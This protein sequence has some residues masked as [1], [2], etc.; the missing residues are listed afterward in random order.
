MGK[1]R[2][3]ILKR[4]FYQENRHLQEVMRKKNRPYYMYNLVID[5]IEYAIPLRSRIR[6]TYFFHTGYTEAGENCG[7]DFSKAVIITDRDRY[8]SSKK[9]R[10]RQNEYIEIRGNEYKIKKA[11]ERYIKKYK[12]AH[13]IVQQGK[14]SKTERELYEYSSLKNYNRELGLS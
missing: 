3:C 1:N 7:I 8:I 10:I 4:I 14:G 6:H 9:V 5:N 2:L 13:R 11:F 12:K